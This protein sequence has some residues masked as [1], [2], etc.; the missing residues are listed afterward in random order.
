MATASPVSD[1]TVLERA[2]ERQ[3]GDAGWGLPRLLLF[4]FAFLY[5]AVYI[6]PFPLNV[7]PKV[8]PW[9][10]KVDEVLR[11]PVVWFADV[12]LGL[13][14]T[15]FPAGSGDTTFNYVQILVFAIVS[16]AG[17][18]VW[19]AVGKRGH[20]PALR[21]RFHIMLRYLLGYMMV[22]YGLAKVLTTQFSPPSPDRLAQQLGDFSPMGLLWTFMGFSTAYCVFTGA[23][24][25][26]GGVLLFSRRTTTLGALVIIGVMINVVMLNSCYDVPVKLL[27]SHLLTMAVVLTLPDARRLLDVLVFHRPT[28]PAL[29][30]PPFRWRR[31]ERLRGWIKAAFLVVTLGWNTYERY[32]HWQESTTTDE[33]PLLGRFEATGFYRGGVLQPRNLDDTSQWRSFGTSRWGYVMIRTMQGP[34]RGYRAVH[35]PIARLLFVLRTRDNSLSYGWLT[36]VRDGDNLVVRG[37]FDAVPIEARMTRVDHEKSELMGRGFH[38]INEVPYNR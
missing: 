19:T 24:E 17:A 8:E 11:I 4:R 34:S 30:R 18:L 38:W 3:H 7:L 16:I 29:V 23:A 25:V 22:S 9:A 26:L 12:V 35:V 28:A 15:V 6:F 37:L 21:D 20:D 33:R 32:E 13:T 27:S 36:Y 5:F 10:E 31:L 1:E 14:I 2:T